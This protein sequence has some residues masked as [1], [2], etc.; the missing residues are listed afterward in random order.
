MRRFDKSAPLNDAP[1][2]RIA[3]IGTSGSGKST[4][5]KRLGSVLGHAVIELDA[6]NWQADWTDLNTHDPPEFVRR[7][8]AAIEKSSWITDGNYSRVLPLI[9]RRASDVIW[10]DYA[11]SVVM[12]RVLRRSLS[13]SLSGRELW[14]DTGNRE[15]WRR[16]LS[17]EHPIR[18]AWDT[19]EHRRVRYEEA[20]AD[21]R[22][23]H[24][25]VHRLRR[26]AE[27]PPLVLTLQNRSGAP[28]LRQ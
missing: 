20:F 25:T 4:L 3:I 23:S 2:V 9:L 16:W 11:R 10:L 14:P 21:R 22:L 1:A 13:R 24:L 6:V 27:V 12:S 5:A 7:V 8:E 26:P 15:R 18:W 19:F 28:I 17:K